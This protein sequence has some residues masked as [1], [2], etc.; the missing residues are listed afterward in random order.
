MA[1]VL[2]THDRGVLA[3]VCDRAVVMYA[4][5]IVEEATV[6]SLCLAPRHPYSAAL[7]AANPQLAA[8]A[9]RFGSSRA[10]CRHR[11]PGPRDAVSRP[12]APVL[13]PNARRNQSSWVQASAAFTP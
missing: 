8:P 2:V 5:E 12:A 10:G 11:Q 3:E 1:L 4:G 7:L 6:E 9:S 13:R